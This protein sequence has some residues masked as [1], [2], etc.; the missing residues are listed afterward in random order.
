[1]NTWDKILTGSILAFALIFM[2][3]A[4]LF[5]FSAAGDT[6][7]ICVDGKCVARYNYR[8][9]TEQKTYISDTE[10]GYNEIVIDAE[11]AYVQKSSCKDQMEVRQGRISKANASL[12]CLPNRLVVQITGGKADADIVAY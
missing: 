11:G 5:V 1:M 2:V 3:C 4:E 8:A 7:E 9:L 10:Y 12:I 6:V